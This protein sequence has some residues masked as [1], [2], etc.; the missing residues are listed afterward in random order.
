MGE[1]PRILLAA[2]P[3]IAVAI[4]L[5]V[6]FPR[7][8]SWIARY[9]A[10]AVA[11]AILIASLGLV[12]WVSATV[13][14]LRAWKAK[15]LATQG[16]FAVCR[17]PIFAVW[18]WAIMPVVALLADSWPFLVADLAI[19]FAA[20]FG[21][22]REEYQLE[23]EFGADWREYVDR[24]PLLFF[25]PRLRG[26][27]GIVL[28]KLVALAAGV[29]VVALAGYLAVSRPIISGLGATLAERRAAMPG[30]E[31]VAAPRI[32]YTQATTI[33]A[34]AEEVWNWLSQ[35]GY[36]RAGWYNIDLINRSIVPDFFIDGRHSSVVIH[37]E[38]LGIQEGDELAIHPMLSLPIVTLDYAKALV[39]FK[40][41]EPGAAPG[42]DMAVSWTFAL[43]PAGSNETRLIAR[44]KSGFSGGV[45]PL[46]FNWLFIDIGGAMIQQP[47]MLWGMRWR[48]ERSWR[49]TV[50]A[51]QEAQPPE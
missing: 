44:F 50:Q 6:L 10:I 29:G 23:L 1:A 2:I 4:A 32:S 49:E 13:E 18:I 25:F 14:L 36:H 24:V 21:A 15:R 19:A 51:H 9:R 22:N 43:E 7:F 8:S 33:Q 39:L 30:D 34:P 16:A 17:H 46:V 11:V 12:F 37:P 3:A 26:S 38:L 41:P 28:L 5:T 47:A 40:G 20:I 45:L 31:L 27:A 35:V 42:A 48:A